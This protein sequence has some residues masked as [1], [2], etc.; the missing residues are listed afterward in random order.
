MSDN[1]YK[2]IAIQNNIVIRGQPLLVDNAKINPVFVEKP[3]STESLEKDVIA[4]KT[5]LQMLSKELAALK[6]ATKP[7]AP[8]HVPP[9][10]N[11]PAPVKP[12]AKPVVNNK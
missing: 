7:A 6:S 5:Q 9:L 1:I 11:K 10:T 3:P 12:A 8:A 4:L 2:T